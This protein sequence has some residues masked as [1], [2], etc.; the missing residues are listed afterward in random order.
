MSDV[1]AHSGS[2]Q[3]YYNYD[4]DYRVFVSDT[5]CKAWDKLLETIDEEAKVQYIAET[6]LPS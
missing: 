1:Q 6:H 2:L 5:H 4:I 3:Y